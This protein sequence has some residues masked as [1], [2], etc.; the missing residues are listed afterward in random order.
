[1]AKVHPE[2]KRA[3]SLCDANE[4]E[5]IQASLPD[6]LA[7]FSR[8]ELTQWQTRARTLRDKWRDVSRGQE[9]RTQRELGRRQNLANARSQ[10]KSELFDAALARISSH[11]SEMSTE[12]PSAPQQT[13]LKRSDR[14]IVQRA[15]R[16]ITKTELKKS[17]R[18]INRKARSKELSAAKSSAPAAGAPNES[19]AQSP[20]TKTKKK[21]KAKKASPSGVKPPEVTKARKRMLARQDAVAF[22]NEKDQEVRR[23]TKKDHTTSLARPGVVGRKNASAKDK[24][25]R[26]RIAAGGSRKIKAHV[27]AANRRAQ[28]RRD[29]K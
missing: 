12:V 24:A 22:Q 5:V 9:R 7:G 26:N 11:L 19:S 20:P 27:A 10:E 4:L 21:A 29:G 28:A 1:M 15:Q 23:E 8:Q 25:H 16:S 6:Q 14:K 3:K 17:Q 13:K 2:L 18:S